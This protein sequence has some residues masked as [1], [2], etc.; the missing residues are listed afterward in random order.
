MSVLLYWVNNFTSIG[1]IDSKKK[2]DKTIPGDVNDS[3]VSRLQIAA[4]DYLTRLV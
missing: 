4:L 1:L 2:K 3:P